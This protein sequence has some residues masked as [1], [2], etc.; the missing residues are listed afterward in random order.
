MQSSQK[1]LY[2]SHG[3]HF[4]HII[5][6]HNLG[7]SHGPATGAIIDGC[8]SGL[9][10]SENDIQKEVNRRKP[11]VGSKIST[12]RREKDKVHILSGVFEGKTTGTPI[13][14]LVYNKDAHPQDYSKSKISIAHLMQ[15]TPMI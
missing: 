12:T 1:I 3:Q 9:D 5:Q 4:W 15:I 8:P 2:L 6:D 10:L 11:Q 13:S 14:L 7:E